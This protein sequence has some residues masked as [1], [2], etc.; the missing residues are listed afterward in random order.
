MISILVLLALCLNNLFLD[1][2]FIYDI[3]EMYYEPEEFLVVPGLPLE[4]VTVPPIPSIFDPE[5]GNFRILIL[6]IAAVNFVVSFLFEKLMNSD[7]FWDAMKKLQCNRHQDKKVT[8][9][10]KSRHEY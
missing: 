1:E 3:F 4:N 2:D 5:Y 8:Q 6:V 10:N 7:R 9:F